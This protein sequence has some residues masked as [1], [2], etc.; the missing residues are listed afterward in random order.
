MTEILLSANGT[1][2]RNETEWLE[3]SPRHCE[4]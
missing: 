4:R 2:E 3:K 1:G